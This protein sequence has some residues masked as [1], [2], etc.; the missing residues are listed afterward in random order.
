MTKE[1]IRYEDGTKTPDLKD[2]YD[3]RTFLNGQMPTNFILAIT[4]YS[5]FINEVRGTMKYGVAWATKEGILVKNKEGELTYKTWELIKFCIIHALS[6]IDLT[7]KEIFETYAVPF[8]N[9]M[10]INYYVSS[11]DFRSVFSKPLIPPPSYIK[12]ILNDL[13]IIDEIIKENINKNRGVK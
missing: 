1:K 7:N 6:N 8:L 12:N 3:V 2:N 10:K 4:Q 13:Q 11:M 9:E 5:T